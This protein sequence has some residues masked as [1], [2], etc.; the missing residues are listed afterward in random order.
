MKHEMMIWLRYALVGLCNSIVGLGLIALLM[1]GFRWT[2]T[3]ATLLGNI[4]GMLFSYGC[5]RFFTF[6]DQG[7][8]GKSLFRFTAVSLFSYIIAYVLLHEPLDKLVM[9][10]FPTV[11]VASKE[12]VVIL[13]EASIYT[14]T[15]FLFHRMYTFN[16]TGKQAV[17][18]TQSEPK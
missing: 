18:E 4:T 2:H 16:T 10:L 8:V 3:S 9:I 6:R 11:W 5:N 13:L 7:K 17:M 1:H 12:D 14:I 15:S